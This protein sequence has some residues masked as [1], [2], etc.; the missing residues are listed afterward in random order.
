MPESSASRA[1]P[2]VWHA[3]PVDEC[4]SVLCTHRGGLTADDAERRLADLGPNALPSPPR[5]PAW[6]RLLAQFHNVLI[7]LLLV[8]GVAAAAL[9]HPVDAAVIFGV[10][11]VNA[12]I[13]F[14]QEGK[15]QHAMEAIGRMLAPKARVL[16]DGHR[17]TLDAE[18]LVPGDVVLL[19]AGDRVPADLRLIESQGLRIDEAALTGESVPVEKCTAT[20]AED[21]AL[22]E[23]V[24][25]AYAGT[26]VAGGQGVGVVVA[27]ANATELGRISALLG[28]VQPLTTPLLRQIEHFGRRLSVVIVSLAVAMVVLGWLLHDTPLLAGFMAGVA[29]AVAAIPEGLPAIIT[30]T[31]AMGVRRMAARQAVI[32]RLP[33]VETLGAVSVICT[34]KT[35]TL[36]CNE[37]VAAR[38]GLA[39]AAWAAEQ[40]GA[41][42]PALL[43]AAVLCNEAAADGHDG[44][45]IERALIRLAQAAG[46]DVAARR[47]AHPRL[48]LLPFSSDYKFMAT[49]HPGRICLK[50]APETVLARCDRQRVGDDEQPLDTDHWHALLDAMAR[51]G[52][53]VLALAEKRLDDDAACLDLAMV[54]R[55]LCLLGLVAFIDPPRPEV[56]DAI[57]ACRSAGIAVKMIT[58]DHAATAAAIAR[59]LEIAGDDGVLTGPELDRLDDRALAE[60]VEAVNVYARATPEHKLRLVTALQACGRVVAMTGDGANDAPALKRADIGVAMGIKGTEAARQAAEMVLAD[61]NFA[62]IVAGVEEGRGVYDN[63]RKALMFILPTNAAQALI[64]LLAVLAGLAV[65]PLTPVLILWVNLVTSVTLALSLAFE[66]LEAGVMKR[67]PRSPTQGLL[68]GYIVWRVVFVGALLTAMS[69]AGFLLWVDG[70]GEPALARTVALNMLVA[71][72]VAYLFNSRRWTAPGWT[73]EALLANPWAWLSVA[74]LA[75]LQAAVTYWPPAQAVFGTQGLGWREWGWI[76]ALSAALFIV[77]ELEKAWLRRW[78]N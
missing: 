65:L 36:T 25:M 31:L 47:E 32:R 41:R 52:L 30:I 7:H 74:V 37:L 48:A 44:D 49:R 60:R 19:K 72:S 20:V 22:A 70:G 76:A 61:D 42:A 18:C 53:R 33:A 67:A 40:A 51:D 11:V 35:G 1:S 56:P 5:R 23:R 39:D 50:G 29:L 15:A 2:P 46:V 45:P 24:G 17:R 78:M 55:G 21:T 6:R 8:A 3:L 27:T 71:G 34:D 38:I 64:I 66:P 77:V 4:L 68:G 14:V 10:V 26:M 28:R 59:A 54:E 16:R 63:I 9:G 43:E 57:A 75:L 12:L 13:G 69:F 58:G 73:P 62:T